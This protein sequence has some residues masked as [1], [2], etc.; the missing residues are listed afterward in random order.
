[1]NA[2]LQ[3][4]IP[5]P[6]L[7]R[8]DEAER[9]RTFQRVAG[10][11]AFVVTVFL[12]ILMIEQPGT[13]GRRVRSIL[14]VAGVSLLLVWLSRRR[15]PALASWLLVAALAVLVSERAYTSGGL[16]APAVQL[17][18]IIVMIAGLLRGTRGG[19]FTAAG[20]FAIGFALLWAER[21]GS[22]PPSEL[23]FTSVT[24]WVYSG[25]CLTLAVI[26]QR[27]VTVT[28]QRALVRAQDENR[29]RQQAEQRLQLALDAGGVGVWEFDPV[30]HLFFADSFVFQL[31]GIP[32]PPDRALR[33]DTW[34]SLVHPADLA[35]VDGA[36]RELAG[37][38]ANARAQFR[39]VRPDGTIRHLEAAGAP[40]FNEAG[41]VARVVGVSRDMTAHLAAEQERIQLVHNLGERVKELRLL[42]NAARLFQREN[43]PADSALLQ[44]LV[45]CLPPAWQYPECC[46]ARITF[47]GSQ[48]AT[49]GWRESQ[50]L[51]FTAF[52]TSDGP[53]LIEVV[54][55]EERPPEVEGP[56]LAEERTLLGSLAEMLV[57]YVELRKHRERLEELIAT[58]T[59]EL[60]E[61]KEDAERANQAKS[62]FL[63]TMSHEIRTPMNAILGY[64]QL[65]R[66]DPVLALSQR[67]KVDV[68]LL[69]GDHLLTLINGVL[70]MARIEAGRVTL[71]VRPFDLRQLIEGVRQMF[72]G[73]AR[74]KEIAL[75]F[76]V[77]PE[78]VQRVTGD[79]GKI[80]QV[81]INLLS[82]AMKFTERGGIRVRATSQPH[83]GGGHTITLAVEDTGPGIGEEDL[84]KIFNVFEQSQLG[85]RAGGTG[86][87]LSIARE[88]AQLMAGDVTADSTLGV[89]TTFIFTGV[90]GT[91]TEEQVKPRSPGTVVRLEAN[92]PIRRVLAVDDRPQN[93]ELVEEL[94]VPIGFDLKTVPSAE[95]GIALHDSWH[96]DLI[97][98]DLRM[99]GMGGVEAIRRLRAAGTTSV[100]VGFTASGLDDLEGEA[101]AAGAVGI[102]HKPYREAELLEKVGRWC[103]VRYVYDLESESVKSATDDGRAHSLTTLLR[104]VP[105]ATVAQLQT[106]AREARVSRIREI[107]GEIAGT[108]AEAAEAIRALAQDFRYDAITTAIEQLRE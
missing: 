46:E 64:A 5:P 26:I 68:I 91:A 65:L 45:E 40:V 74:E 1:M 31:H 35:Q 17:F 103:G 34:S 85:A 99:P 50:W 36:L 25:L 7:N 38:K 18:L 20:F 48:V 15:G 33:Y 84:A 32:R 14:V 29:A 52:H 71:D 88:F 105:A 21:T 62:R 2:F 3:W 78:L 59:R 54:Y 57:G 69:S 56:F 89:G 77:S 95:E 75:A 44:E 27:E 93:L 19:A 11:L 87:G 43:P 104:G 37:G 28:L 51:Q 81:L 63:S 9:M 42:H 83:T 49:A 24:L 76:D 47:R 102:L 13:I 100:L 80:R 79:A 61:A 72:V 94:L 97:L 23:K 107:A 55:L 4:L 41:T 96:P 90:V 92:Q 8:G 101:L 86:L 16:Q 82:N 60:R 108:S 73:S 10:G 98:M 70:E 53:G 58:R 106:A 39:V 30:T 12:S 67:Q 6:T 66:R 22:L